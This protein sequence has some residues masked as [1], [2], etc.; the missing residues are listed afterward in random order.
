MK[1]L[2]YLA[3]I[4]VAALAVSCEKTPVADDITTSEFAFTLRVSEV[5]VDYAKISVKHN[6]PEEVTWYGFVAEDKYKPYSDC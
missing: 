2:L 3:S 5:G 4:L 6:G 1:K